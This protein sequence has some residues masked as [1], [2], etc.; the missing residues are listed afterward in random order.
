MN[1]KVKKRIFYV[2]AALFVLWN[3]YRF[4]TFYNKEKEARELIDQNIEYDRMLAEKLRRQ[5]GNVSTSNYSGSYKQTDS[6][7]NSF[8]YSESNSYSGTSS[9]HSSGSCNSGYRSYDDGYDSVY[10]DDDYDSDRYEW[11]L[12]Y[13]D[14]VDDA[15]DELE[16][17][18]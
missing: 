10:E 7:K 2:V 6:N 5:R 17:D 11:D 4:I 13:A 8:S 15:M 14:G 16:D 3:C 12:D 1:Q 9:Y 18:W